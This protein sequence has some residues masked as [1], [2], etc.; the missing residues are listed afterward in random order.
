MIDCQEENPTMIDP[1][2]CPLVVSFPQFSKSYQWDEFY[3]ESWPLCIVDRYKVTILDP[4]GLTTM[5]RFDFD[6][7]FWSL[8]DEPGSDFGGLGELFIVNP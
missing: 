1:G 4:N 6:G 8:V 7:V 5:Y 3:F 2:T